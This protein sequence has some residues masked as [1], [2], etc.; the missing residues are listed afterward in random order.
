MARIGVF[1]CHCGRNIAGT[2]DVKKVV[3]EVKKFPDVVHAEDYIYMCSDTGQKL[4]QQRIIEKKLDGVVMANCS[5]TLHERTFRNAAAAVGLNPYRVEV[6]NIR[7]QVSWPHEHDKEKATEKAIKIIKATILKVKKNMAL[8]PL[9]APLVKKALVIGG[10][11]AGMQAALDIADAGYEVY[12]VEKEPSIGGRMAQLAETFPTLDCPQCIM[13]PK[14][15]AVGQ[16]P[17]I[18]LMTYS[19]VEEVSGYVGNFNVKIRRKAPYVRWD[20]CKGCGDCAAVCPKKVPNEFDRGLSFR[21]AIYRPFEQAVPNVYTIDYESCLHCPVPQCAKACE[22]NAIDFSMKD[23]IVEVNVGAIIVATGFDLMPLKNFPEY[24][25]GKYPDVIDALQFERLISA[26]GP[27]GGKLLRPSDGKVPKSVVFIQCAGSRDPAN[28]VPYCSRI[29]CMYTAKEA[30]LY[31]HLVPDGQ[32]YVF[33]I[34]IRS[35]GKGYEEFVQRVMEEDG[36]LYLRGKVSK[37]YDKDGQLYVMGVDTLTG[38]AVEVPADL[39]V[40]APAMLPSKGARE[41]AKK[42]RIPTDIYGWFNEAHLKLRPVETTTPGIFIAGTAQFPKDITDTVS[43]AS[44][45]AGKVLSLFGHEELSHEPTVAS[46]D[47][48]ICSGCGFCEAACAYDAIKVHPKKKIA[49]VNESLCEGCG[50]CSAACP[51]GAVQVRNM[52]KDQIFDMI[53]ILAE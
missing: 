45:A 24:G 17:N 53:G 48:E 42:L 52:K 15:N 31:K 38:K 21:K 18:H 1:V 9:K 10:G 33:Y 13:T 30:H 8:H 2:I 20:L 41:L 28:G 47:T 46:V 35:N 25:G 29:C 6:A 11:I 12:L 23:E 36:V 5:P 49:I 7:E 44:G 4:L 32:A 40:L 51:S 14:M 43:Q 22:Q 34:D 39:V 37:V 19:E 16:H 3:E 26:S 27:T 50:A